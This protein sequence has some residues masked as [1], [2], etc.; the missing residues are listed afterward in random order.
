M[1]V[2]FMT[3]AYP[4]ADNQNIYSDLMREFERNGHKVY[5]A[6]TNEKRNSQK[7]RLTN[8]S[9]IN[10]LR[11]RTGN[12]T[13]SVNLIEKGFTTLTL[14]YVIRRAINKY[15]KSIK[16]DLII[17]STPPIT[18]G[19]SVNFFKKR[20]NATTYL[21][22]K[23]IFPQN[24]IDIGLIKKSS[25]IYKY[26][27]S[28]EKNLYNLSDYIGCMSDANV[29]YIINKNPSLKT[30]RIEVCPNTIEPLN[31]KKSVDDGINIRMK[32]GIPK[33]KVIFIYGGNLGRP[34]GIDFLI[35]CLS[36]NE[37]NDKAFIVIVGSGTEYEKL[38]NHFN[39]MQLQ[40]SKLF[41][42]IPK[43]D[44]ESLVSTCDV[45]LIFLDHRFTIPNFPSRI[46]SYMQASI[47]IL[48]F[49]D[50]CTDIGKVIEDGKFGLWA[51]SG[52]IQ[53]FQDSI[54]LLCSDSKLREI[55]GK[56]AKSY[57]EEY[58]TVK[59]SYEIIIKHFL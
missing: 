18:F 40:N 28:K 46:L 51:E 4:N 58:Y 26:F 30:D 19:R 16:F 33:D 25:I 13:G 47:P 59:Q 41:E 15:F 29:N 52:D 8:E 45:G 3:I 34:Q 48:A 5:V 55:M 17:Y 39:K 44:Y 2:L 20:D 49:T 31:I 56:N 23:D 24:A 6:C 9:G 50:K 22:L 11:V 38:K 1:N 7:T 57:L 10:I 21:L 36:K 54:S 42:H 53:A 43:T 32:Y 35:E 12:L 37:K 14:E 27:R